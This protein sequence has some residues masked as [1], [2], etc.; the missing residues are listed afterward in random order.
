MGGMVPY[1]NKITLIPS[2]PLSTTAVI[3]HFYVSIQKPVCV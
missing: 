3:L 1:M 2:S